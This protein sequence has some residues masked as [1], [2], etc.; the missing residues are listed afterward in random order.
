MSKELPFFKFYPSEWL[1]GRINMESTIDQVAFLRTVCLYWHKGCELNKNELLPYV[2]ESRI[3]SLSLKKYIEISYC[4]DSNEHNISVPFLDEQKVELGGA[5]QR[6]VNAGQKGGLKTQEKKRAMLK[7]LDVEVE[8]EKDKTREDYINEAVN[9]PDPN[10]RM[11]RKMAEKI[12]D[13]QIKK[14]VIVI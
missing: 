14:G 9:N 8:K 10:Q 11:T 5:H 6:R 1:L 13:S 2:T 3:E 4:P 7:Q 12:V